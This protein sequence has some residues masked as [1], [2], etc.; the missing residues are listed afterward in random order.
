M[1]RYTLGISIAL[2]IRSFDLRWSAEIGKHH[3]SIDISLRWSENQTTKK[4]FFKA[5]QGAK[6][7]CYLLKELYRQG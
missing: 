6:N 5:N 7:E 3:D 1:M 2:A 4:R